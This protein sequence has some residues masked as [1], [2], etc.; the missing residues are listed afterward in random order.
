MSAPTD[1]EILGGEVNAA[2][3]KLRKRRVPV[4]Q[5]S[6]RDPNPPHRNMRLYWVDGRLV[7]AP[8][9]VEFARNM[10]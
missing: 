10:P 8:G 4:F 2:I 6:K 5:N 9:L 3:H 7:N 1:A